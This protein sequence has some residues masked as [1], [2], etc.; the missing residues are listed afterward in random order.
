MNGRDGDDI[1]AKVSGANA[2]SGSNG[3]DTFVID[4]QIALEIVTD[5]IAADG[6]MID[7]T[8]LLTSV[9]DTETRAD[10]DDN[11]DREVDGFVEAVAPPGGDTIIFSDS[12]AGDDNLSDAV[13]LNGTFVD[14][15]IEILFDDLN[16][17]SSVDT[18]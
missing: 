16:S 4:D 15:T 18:V 9:S 10:D 17:D 11:V 12:N 7:L 1:L 8:G 5:F 6:D 2:L 14:N 3:A 13:Q